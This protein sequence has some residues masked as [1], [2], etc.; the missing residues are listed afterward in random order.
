MNVS[1]SQAK[2]QLTELARRAE[3]GEEVILTRHGTP[4][5]R[6]VPIEHELDQDAIRQRRLAAMNRAMREA[7]ERGPDGGPCAAR[8]ADFLYDE[9]G[10]PA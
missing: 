2:A 5:V 1:L 8:S 9:N 7:A 4:A 10:L 6:L 3:A